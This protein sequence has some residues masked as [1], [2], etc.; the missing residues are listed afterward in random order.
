MELG[1]EVVGETPGGV[2]ATGSIM[3]GPL[4]MLGD[5]ELGGVN[6]IQGFNATA[7][8][9]LLPTEDSAFFRVPDGMAGTRAV[10][11]HFLCFIVLSETSSFIGS[12]HNFSRPRTSI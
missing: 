10:P 6:A 9:L 11:M 1:L 2:A 4:V 8:A 7:L 3:G 12:I 5:L